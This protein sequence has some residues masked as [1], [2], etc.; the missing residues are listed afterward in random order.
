MRYIYLMR[1]DRYTDERGKF[2]TLYGIDVWRLPDHDAR[3]CRSYPGLF[4]TP[5]EAEEL[6]R[7]LTKREASPEVMEGMEGRMKRFGERRG[8][9]RPSLDN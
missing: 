7:T 2:Y 9:Q 6:A 3:L 8:G 4:T 1:T 5:R